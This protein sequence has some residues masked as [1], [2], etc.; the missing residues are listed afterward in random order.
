MNAAAPASIRQ[1]QAATRAPLRRVLRRREFGVG[2]LL[3]LTGLAVSALNPN[4]ATF[5]NVR[6]LLVQAAPTAIVACALTFVIVTGEIDISVGS[7]MGLLAALLGLLASPAHAGLPP[8][9]AV[10]VT[11]AAGAAIG[12]LN[13]VLVAFGGAPS[14]IV[15]LGMLTA[16]RGVTELLMGGEWIT[17]LPPGLRVLGTGAWLGIPLS[18]W[19]GGAVVAAAAVF[20]RRTPL[21][22]AHLRDRQ[23]SGCGA[24][25]RVV[26][27]A[28]GPV[29][30][31]RCRAC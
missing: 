23:Q 17:D 28:R 3:I 7:L 10:L 24:P 12:L 8:M 6:E 20:A 11:L 21:G 30:V 13:G 5:V 26:A 18:I 2:V 29:C 1:S 31:H 19:V 22:L 15:T 25:G 4:F 9:V 14:I 27:A 16:L